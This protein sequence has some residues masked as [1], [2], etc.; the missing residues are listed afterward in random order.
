LGVIAVQ[1]IGKAY[2]EDIEKFKQNYADFMKKE[3]PAIKQNLVSINARDQGIDRTLIDKMA[4]YQ[5][6]RFMPGL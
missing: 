4:A 5:N 6:M 3:M 2:Y 1:E